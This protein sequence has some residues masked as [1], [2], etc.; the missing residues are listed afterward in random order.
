VNEKPVRGWCRVTDADLHRWAGWKLVAAATRIAR[1]GR[2]RDLVRTV[3]AEVFGTVVDV[4]KRREHFAGVVLEVV[5]KRRAIA[6]LCSCE[7]RPCPH[8]VAV[9]VAMRATMLARRPVPLARHQDRRFAQLPSEEPETSGWEP[10]ADD[11]AWLPDVWEEERAGPAKEAG[12]DDDIP[13]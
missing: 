13:F 8:A 5:G 12:H 6:S 4:A 11:G 9:A 3:E 7:R 1:T 10:V 2:V